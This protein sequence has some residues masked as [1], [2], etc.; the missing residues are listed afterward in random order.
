MLQNRI[1]KWIVKILFLI[2]KRQAKT[3]VA[4]FGFL[5]AVGLIIIAWEKVRDLLGIKPKENEH[6]EDFK[7][8]MK[9][10]SNKPVVRLSQI[11]EN[12]RDKHQQNPNLIGLQLLNEHLR[13]THQQILDGIMPENIKPV[14]VRPSFINTMYPISHGGWDMDDSGP[15]VIQWCREHGDYTPH[16][17]TS[18]TRP[19]KCIFCEQLKKYN[20]ST[21]GEMWGEC[22]SCDKPCVVRSGWGFCSSDCEEMYEVMR[23]AEQEDEKLAQ[24][25]SAWQDEDPQYQDYLASIEGERRAEQAETRF[26]EEGPYRGPDYDEEPF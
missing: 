16:K 17:V 2:I 1:I 9:G 8:R 23:R 20:P 13:N 15:I 14:D 26:F 10:E 24:L 4:S 25:M 22:V 3:A 18:P 7:R 11:R 19:V 21:D 6:L 12:I 5:F